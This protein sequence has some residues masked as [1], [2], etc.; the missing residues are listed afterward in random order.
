[1]IVKVKAKIQL[2][3]EN[4]SAPIVN[5]YVSEISTFPTKK[6]GN[7]YYSVVLNGIVYV[8]HSCSYDSV[9]RLG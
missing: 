2:G 8:I 6:H 7:Y 5:V 9:T 3:P 4:Y 1:L